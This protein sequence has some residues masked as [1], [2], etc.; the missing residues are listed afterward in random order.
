MLV[1][2]MFGVAY[3]VRRVLTQFFMMNMEAEKTRDALIQVLDN[4]PDAVLMLQ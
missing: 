1:T 4:L 2:M 3:F